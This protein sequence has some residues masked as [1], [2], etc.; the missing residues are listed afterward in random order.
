MNRARTT[1]AAPVRI[2][3]AGLFT[4]AP[5]SVSIEP[6]ERPGDG[7]VLHRDGVRFAAEFAALSAVPAHPA[8]ARMPARNTTLGARNDGPIVHTVEHLLAALAGLGISDAVVRAET[9]ELPIGD[10]SACLFT[11]PITDAGVRTLSHETVEPIRVRSPIRVER[12]G[13][14]ITIEPSDGVEFIYRLDY[15]PGSPIP[16]GEASWDGSVDAF[17]RG[18]APARTFCL[19]AEA[20]AMHAMGLFEHLTPRDMLVFGPEGPIDNTL[21]F[22]DEPARH[23]LLDLIGDLS[24]AGR[25]ILGRVVAERSGH[26]LPH[27]AVGRLRAVIDA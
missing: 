14:S 21:R 6:A 7:I 27:A 1:L 19:L 20:E 4:G 24:L 12:D 11:D 22:A 3:G 26:A 13:A 17:V 23:K 16:P 2:E 8:F 15:G 10:G 9:D 5:A 25:P 18:I